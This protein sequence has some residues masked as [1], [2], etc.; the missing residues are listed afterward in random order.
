MA[1]DPAPGP[2]IPSGAIK[3]FEGKICP[4]GWCFAPEYEDKVYLSPHFTDGISWDQLR[5][6]HPDIHYIRKL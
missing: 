1:P 3:L 6:I 2:L 5:L 4:P